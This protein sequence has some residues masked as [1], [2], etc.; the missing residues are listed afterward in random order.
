MNI[1]TFTDSPFRLHQ[2]FEAAA[3]VYLAANA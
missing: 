1:K 3:M 2:D